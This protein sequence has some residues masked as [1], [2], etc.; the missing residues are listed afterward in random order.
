MCVCMRV[1]A[2]VC[3]GDG[4]DGLEK[5]EEEAVVVLEGGTP[6]IVYFSSFAVT[7]NYIICGA[8]Y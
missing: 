5:E 1:C 8:K 7:I 6:I 2:C 3:S 4:G